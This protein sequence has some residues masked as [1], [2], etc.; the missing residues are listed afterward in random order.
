MIL[1]VQICRAFNSVNF[2]ERIIGTD[3][4]LILKVCILIANDIILV[5]FFPLFFPVNI[6]TSLPTFHV[7][8]EVL[9]AFYVHFRDLVQD[10]DIVFANVLIHVFQLPNLPLKGFF[11]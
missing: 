1:T 8:L 9:D 2:A 7:L 4:L 11:F 6:L 10:F 5:L 3:Q